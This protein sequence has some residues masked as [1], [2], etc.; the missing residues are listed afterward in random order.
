[1]PRVDTGR[2]AVKA[3]TLLLPE[4]ELAGLVDVDL[5]SEFIKAAHGT[6]E[7]LADEHRVAAPV[8]VAVHFVLS[9]GAPPRVR[10][11]WK[12]AAEPALAGPLC[13]ALVAL[14]P[15]SVRGEVPFQIEATVHP[16]P[17]GS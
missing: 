12:G 10:L 13:A 1:M 11:A 2:I 16:S 7:R 5:L 9:P 17:L 4:E 6:M 14:D 3:V 15:V 8:T